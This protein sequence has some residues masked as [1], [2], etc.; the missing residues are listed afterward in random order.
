VHRRVAAPRRLRRRL[1]VAFVVVAAVSAGV[2]AAGSYL[3][4]QQGRLRD[5]AN[6][7]VSQARLNLIFAGDNLPE[8]PSRRE[9]AAVL[10]AFVGG[11]FETVLVVGT[12]Q[13]PSVPSVADRLPPDVRELVVRNRLGYERVSIG[14][15]PYLVVGGQVPGR[16]ADG[17]FFFS[18]EGLREDLSLLGKVAMGGWLL[19]VVVAGLVGSLLARRTLGPVARASQ[20][21]RSL[22]EGLLDTRLPVAGSDEFAQWAE[23]FNEMAQALES[24]IVELSEARDRERRFTSDVAHE[25]RTPLAAL[26]GE[27]SLLKEQLD[28]MPEDARRPSELLVEDVGRLRRMVEELM[29]ISRL[30]AGQEPVRTETVDLPALLAAVVRSRGWEGRVRLDS[31]PLAMETD[32]RRIERIVGNLVGNAIEHGREDVRIRAGQLDGGVFVEVSDQGKGIPDAHR[33]H[34]F[35]RFYKADPARTGQGSGLGLAIAL[36]NAHLLGGDIEVW[37]E[38]GQGSRFTLRLPVTGPLRAG[39]GAVSPDSDDA[40]QSETKG[41]SSI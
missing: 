33:P 20:A 23:S 17:Y 39:E 32:R 7:S 15:I 14:K 6:R 41:G 40:V 2:L 5:S 30:D 28:Q 29:E 13:F 21:A 8:H 9:V 26:V 3:L 36:E 25:L 12:R 18:E 35:E 1:T 19:I 10:D 34:L 37:S 22:A 4:V 16:D 24:K 27:A 11:G 38:P 31:E